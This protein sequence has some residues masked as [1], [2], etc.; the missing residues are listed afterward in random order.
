MS[1]L[2]EHY[3]IELEG[4]VTGPFHCL[5]NLSDVQTQMAENTTHLR[6]SVRDQAE[7]LGL[8]RQLRDHGLILNKLIRETPANNERRAQ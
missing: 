3:H 5:D 1:S 7:L 8:L 4:P 6:F 2:R